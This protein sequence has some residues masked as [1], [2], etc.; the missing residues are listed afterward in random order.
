MLIDDMRE[1]RTVNDKA[2]TEAAPTTTPNILVRN[3]LHDMTLSY[4]GYTSEFLLLYE[5]VRTR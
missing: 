5:S 2:S 3:L 4:A 1:P